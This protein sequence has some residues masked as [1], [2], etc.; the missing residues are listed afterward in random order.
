[1][2]TAETSTGPAE[3]TKVSNDGRTIAGT[4]SMVR[5]AFRTAAAVMSNS[6]ICSLANDS[7][8]RVLRPISIPLTSRKLVV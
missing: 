8:A 3:F 5:I 7:L 4:F 2:L 1:M 6:L